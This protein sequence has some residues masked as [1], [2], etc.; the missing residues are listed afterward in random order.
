[1]KILLTGGLGFMGKR[2]VRKYGEI[3]EII[4]FAR[5]NSIDKIQN[6]EL[7]KN[8]ILESGNVEDQTVIDVITRHKPDVVI[9]LAALTGL[10]KCH[11]D[12]DK[13]FKVNVFGTYNIVNACI[14]NNS[15]LIFISSREV[16]GET[17]S[18]KSKEEHI[19]NPNNTYGLTKMLGEII[20]KNAS[21]LHDLDYTILRVT[22]V[23][24]PEG[25]GYGAQI[26]IKDAISKKNI[27]IL[28]GTQRL[29]Y[30]FVDDII[31]LFGKI[32]KNPNT[33]KQTY[34]LGSKNT[35]SVNEFVSNIK[36][37]IKDSITIEHLPMRDTETA[38]F[39]PDLDKIRNELD[40][41]PNT[42]LID[43]LKKTIE[44]Y[45]TH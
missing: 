12:S 13:A 26:M 17:K 31:N 2:F 44:W 11:E 30:I 43:G 5:K 45:S 9:H 35:L 27:K 4:I 39:E 33:I 25:D 21:L 22:N 23:Y 6:N 37:L 18:Q 20:I 15:K 10:K 38:N 34:N 1:M 8:T 3:H 29:N 40:F 36:N 16:Y 41:E 19:L 24:G 42:S 14:K 7:F 32:L 28:G